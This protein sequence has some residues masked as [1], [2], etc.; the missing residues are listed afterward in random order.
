MRND[1]IVDGRHDRISMKVEG[2][3]TVTFLFIRASQ[4]SFLCGV[5]ILSISDSTCPIT[6]ITVT[7]L[8]CCSIVVFFTDIY[9]YMY[10]FSP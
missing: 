4:N 8:C 5:F 2:S 7:S 6:S 9:H 1:F 10:V 3:T